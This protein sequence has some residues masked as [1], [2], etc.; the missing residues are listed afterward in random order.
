MVG[1]CFQKLKPQ[2]TADI[3]YGQ[4]M[5]FKIYVFIYIYFVNRIH[6]I[7]RI[8]CPNFNS[9]F[10]TFLILFIPIYTHLFYVFSAP[11]AMKFGSILQENFYEVSLE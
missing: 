8:L 9:K 10:M 1:P 4:G 5:V 2:L 6:N 3:G 11:I 7:L